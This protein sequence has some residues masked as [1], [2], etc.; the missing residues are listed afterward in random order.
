MTIGRII[1]GHWGI[2]GCGEWDAT[3]TVSNLKI[4]DAVGN[5]LH[6]NGGK[7][8]LQPKW[9]AIPRGRL[10]LFPNLEGGDCPFSAADW[11]HHYG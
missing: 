2:V 5:V 6:S 8:G 7:S 3:L 9:R 4:R 10:Q 1:A 11:L